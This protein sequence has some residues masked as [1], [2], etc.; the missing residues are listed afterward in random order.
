[1]YFYNEINSLQKCDIVRG[2]LQRAGRESAHATSG[3]AEALAA[4]T[5]AQLQPPP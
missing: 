1:M 4:G 5:S 2:S 3:R